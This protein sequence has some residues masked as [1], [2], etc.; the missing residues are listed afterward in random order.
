M[1]FSQQIILKDSI[2]NHVWFEDVNKNYVEIGDVVCF[3]ETDNSIPFSGHV[4]KIT[5][6]RAMIEN[7]KGIF[8]RAHNRTMIIKHGWEL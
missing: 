1:K 8:T 5:E 2:V 4:I 6:K 7:N 3:S